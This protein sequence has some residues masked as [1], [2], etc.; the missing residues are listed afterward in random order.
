M[1]LLFET[2]L[3]I[4]SVE[5]KLYFR[6]IKPEIHPEPVLQPDRFADGAGASIY[7]TVLY[8]GGRY[9]MW[10][11]AW[12]KDWD[13]RDVDLVGYAESD[14]G[15]DWHKPELGIVAYGDQPNNLCNLGFHSPSV[16]IDPHAPASHRYRATGYT[17]PGRKGARQQIERPGYYTAHSADGLHWE[18]DQLAPRWASGDVITS[19]YHPTQD[20]A[21]VA[22]KFSPRVNGFQRRSIWN[23]ELVDG[24]WSDA[25]AALLP[26]E[27]DDICAVARGY[28]SGD[29]YGMGMLPAG[30]G[31]VGLLW[32]FRHDLP[33]TGGAGVGVF[34]SVDVSLVYQAGRGDR[35]LHRPGREDFISHVQTPWM[36]GGIYTASCPVEVGDEQW[37]YITGTVH[38]HAW[39]LN[40]HWQLIEPRQREMIESGFSRI[41]VARWPKDRLFGFRADPEGVLELALRAQDN[42]FELKLNYRTDPGGSIRVELPGIAGY[43]LDNA[44]PLTGD[45]LSNTV[46]WA[47]GTAIPPQPAGVVRARLHLDCAEV[48]AYETSP[49]TA[50]EYS[51]R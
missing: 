27:F 30:R 3:D 14:N 40:E 2:R 17:G 48:Y 42:P 28:A 25:H 37:L 29:Y 36:A 41:G 35:W 46:A 4:A 7:G 26:D 31:T 12:P 19:V 5:G 1:E 20:R 51:G 9:R 32:Q 18:L 22:L 47:T 23:A 8:D 43:E 24:E 15:L 38:S 21:I 33:R 10:Y 50:A 44:V 13:G 16:F 6:Q 11:Q 45:S 34:G 49:A 39:Y